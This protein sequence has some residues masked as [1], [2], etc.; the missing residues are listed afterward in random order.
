MNKV[1]SNHDGKLDLVEFSA[2]FECVLA[3]EEVLS[4]AEAKFKELNV[5]GTG[6]LEAKEI[7]NLM[8][9]VLKQY[10]EK[11]PDENKRF[12]MSLLAKVDKNHDSRI[13]L[14]E[15]T[16]LWQDI[17][18]RQDLIERAEKKFKEL[19]KD[20]SGFL[21]KEELCEVLL[22]WSQKCKTMEVDV[23]AACRELITALDV[24][25]DGKLN[26]MEFVTLFEH[27]MAKSG[28]YGA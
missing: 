18:E 1:D 2:L 19:D 14:A 9:I 8:E 10:V 17:R 24:D 15:F 13:D 3:R 27:T 26:L 25:G 22:E 16:R 6:A 5:G 28:V 21:E 12:R 11:T 23:D 20:N 7:D 4:S